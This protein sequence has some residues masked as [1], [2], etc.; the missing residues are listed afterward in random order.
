M[1]RIWL[2]YLSP[3]QR[4]DFR[5][6]RGRRI[7]LSRA[8]G[9]YTEMAHEYGPRHAAEFEK[10]LS[11]ARCSLTVLDQEIATWEHTASIRYTTAKADEAVEKSRAA[12]RGPE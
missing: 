11:A 10:Q 2:N 8:I 1:K 7:S 9:R 5:A 6:L 4:D 3:A 12:S